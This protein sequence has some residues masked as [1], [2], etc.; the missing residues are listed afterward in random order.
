MISI[1]FNQTSD[2]IL[3]LCFLDIRCSKM[4]PVRCLTTV[5]SKYSVTGTIS[6]KIEVMHFIYTCWFNRIQ[7]IRE[8]KIEAASFVTNWYMVVL[9]MSYHNKMTV[10]VSSSETKAP[11]ISDLTIVNSDFKCIYCHHLQQELETALL[12]LKRAKKNYRIS[13]RRDKLCSTEHHCK[14]TR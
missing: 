1:G 7:G 8:V 14:H 13:T 6:Q 11:S 5:F 4:K 9:A 3:L 10:V 2:G 12:E